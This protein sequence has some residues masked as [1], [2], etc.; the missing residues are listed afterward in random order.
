[1]PAPARPGDSI[2]NILWKLVEEAG[3]TPRPGDSERD[4]LAKYLTA[5]GGT[6]IVGDTFYDI[7]VRI[8][9]FKGGVPRPGDTVWGLLVKWLE[10]LGECRGCG[11]SQHNL[12]RKILKA[13]SE[14]SP[15]GAPEIRVM[16]GV[17]GILDGQALAIDFGNIIDGVDPS[18]SIVFTVFNDGD[19][20]LTL[21]AVSVPSGYTLTDPLSGT[22]TPG[23]S[24]SFTVRLNNSTP[25]TKSGNV[26]FSTNDTN[27]NPFNF[28]ITG[29]VVVAAAEIRVQ[30]GATNI[31]DGQLG[32]IDF[33]QACQT[34]TGPIKTFTVFND[35]NINLTTSGLTVPT[36]FTITSGL[37]ATIPP[38]SS[39]TFSVQLPDNQAEDNYSGNISFANNDSNE[40]PFNFPVA[41]S[42]ANPLVLDN[43]FADS[44]APWQAELSWFW[45]GG[46]CLPDDPAFFGIEINE[47]SGG[48]GDI[49]FEAGSARVHIRVSD[50]NP[51]SWIARI[52]AFDGDFNRISDW[53]ESG[54]IN[55]PV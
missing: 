48:F 9:R 53:R 43:F 7:L 55:G 13:E 39:T 47:D 31:A 46:D 26:S 14:S 32:Q 11:D 3:G 8:V 54:E 51:H 16:R 21:G 29:T 30:E 33:G 44:G 23:N 49:Q 36:G 45:P 4:L 40:N 17:T 12:W 50:G 18:V 10:T 2:Y 35:G 25:G 1:M 22:I 5:I 37:A 34:I 27:E 6:P 19:S 20:D 42:V 15:E 38:A 52:A 41:G 24:D 28:P